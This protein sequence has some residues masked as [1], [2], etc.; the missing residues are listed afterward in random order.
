MAYELQ[1]GHE[2]RQSER[3]ARALAHYALLSTDSVAIR[4]LALDSVYELIARKRT[5]S[6]CITGAFSTA[7]T[8]PSTSSDY[9]P[10]AKCH[11]Q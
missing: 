7:Y 11:F 9:H 10:N 2:T 5:T 3:D 6:L 4:N 8:G 1:F